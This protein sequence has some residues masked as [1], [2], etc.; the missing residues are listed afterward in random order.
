MPAAEPSL[1]P[2]TNIAQLCRHWAERTPDVE[3]VVRVGRGPTRIVTF[4][5]LDERVDRIAAGLVARGFGRGDR[6]ALMVRD[7]LEFITLTFALFRVGGVIVLIDPGMGVR[8]MLDC[9]AS[10]RPDGFVGV[11]AAHVA[12][13]LSFG[14]FPRASKNVCVGPGLPGVVNLREVERADAVPADESEGGD[15]AIIFTSGSTGPAKG[16]LYEHRMFAAQVRMIR[17]EYDIRPGT[18]DLPC[19]PLFGLFNVGMGVTSVIPPIDMAKPAKADPAVIVDT[20]NRFGCISA[21]ASPAIWRNV[22]RYCRDGKGDIKRLLQ[23]VSAGA[24]V[25]PVA[26]RQLREC[27]SG[28]AEIHTPYGATECLPVSTIS[29]TEIAT[30]TGDRTEHGHGTCVGRVFDGVRI[31]VI[32]PFDGPIGSISEVKELPTGEIGEVI[33]KSPAGT[34]EYVDRPDATAAAKIPDGDGFWHRMGDMGYVDESGRLW[35]CGRKAHVVHMAD[36][37]LYPVMVEGILVSVAAERRG[38]WTPFPVAGSGAEGAATAVAVPGPVPPG[39][40][41]LV[42]QQ[43]VARDA[44]RQVERLGAILHDT[45]IPVDARHN[46]KVRREL[47]TLSAEKHPGRI[48]PLSLNSDADV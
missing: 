2:V 26:I 15:A 46:T 44:R 40:G 9:L 10:V 22:T 34:R 13:W 18:R 19:F 42:V 39:F 11:R 25:P 6:V 47:L 37:P 16:V 27:L 33:V 31:K 17:D 3:A 23:V 12:R 28:D 48:E 24:P 21:Y 45:A 4:R 32:E 8:P 1:P 38:D 5:E 30:E 43:S 29:G 20:V 41:R 35:F 14:K 7:G 36:G